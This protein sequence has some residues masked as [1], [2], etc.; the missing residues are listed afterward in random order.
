[1]A[2]RIPYVKSR[3]PGLPVVGSRAPR[4][5]NDARWHHL[6]TQTAWRKCSEAY[7]AARPYCELCL[8]LDKRM[9]EAALVHHE[10]E[11]NVER[12]LDWSGL[13]S[14]CRRHHAIITH[15]ENRGEVFIYPQRVQPTPDE[16]GYA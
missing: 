9:V 13:W 11:H 1:M 16:P 15:A 5:E 4:K 7:R 10:D 3:R 6:L 14:L 8:A 12:L 2:S